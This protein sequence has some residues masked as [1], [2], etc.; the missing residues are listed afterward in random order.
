MVK[1]ETTVL[2][3]AINFLLLIPAMFTSVGV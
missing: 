1:T 2:E 3:G